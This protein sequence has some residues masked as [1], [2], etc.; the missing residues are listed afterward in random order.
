VNTDWKE[1]GM[2]DDNEKEDKEDDMGEEEE[3]D[4]LPGASIEL[5]A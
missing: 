5:Q 4:E 3:E 1:D 2:Y